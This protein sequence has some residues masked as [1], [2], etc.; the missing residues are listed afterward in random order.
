MVG[1]GTA[2]GRQLAL[3]WLM[4]AY[5]ELIESCSRMLGVRATNS[6]AIWRYI[7]LRIFRTGCT[8]IAPHRHVQV[9]NFTPYVTKIRTT[10]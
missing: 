1:S 6:H 3:V 5:V 7:E 8:I 10:Y 4:D 2:L 9:D